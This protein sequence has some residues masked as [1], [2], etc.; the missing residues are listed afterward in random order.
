LK[1]PNGL[2]LLLL[3]LPS[4]PEFPFALLI[5]FGAAI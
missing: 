5:G 1:L 2:L 3:L 4:A